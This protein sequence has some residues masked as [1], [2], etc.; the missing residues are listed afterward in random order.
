MY[1]LDVLQTREAGYLKPEDYRCVYCGDEES[2][3]LWVSEWNCEHHYKSFICKKCG[4]KT[5][6]KVDFHGSGHDSWNLE[7]MVK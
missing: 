5:Y 6:V 7:E 1:N 4:K 2:E 3:R